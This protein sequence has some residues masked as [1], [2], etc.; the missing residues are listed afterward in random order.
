MTHCDADQ[1]A[2][3]AATLL[4]PPPTLDL[5]HVTPVRYTVAEAMTAVEERITASAGGDVPGPGRRLRR[6]DPCGRAVP[7]D[8]G[9]VP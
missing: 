3:M 2:R 6:A 1:L 7:G 9:A 5:S 8:P 4:R